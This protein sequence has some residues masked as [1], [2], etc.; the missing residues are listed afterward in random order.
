MGRIVNLDLRK[1]GASAQ[2]ILFGEVEVQPTMLRHDGA[3]T[4]LPAPTQAGLSAGL[5]SLDL[6]VSPDGPEP[7]WAYKVV[8]RDFQ[9][10]RAW[11]ELVGVP[12]GATPLPYPDLPRF[13]TAIP[14]EVTATMMQNWADTA[15]G[16]AEEAVAAADRAEAPTDQMAQNLINDAA[17]LTGTALRDTIGTMAVQRGE[18]VINVRDYGAAG[19][20]ATDDTDAIQAAMDAAWGSFGQ[21]GKLIFPAGDYWPRLPIK[22]RSGVAIE[23]EGWPI[24][25]RKLGDPYYAIFA[26]TSDG[27]RGYGSGPS[28]WTCTGIEFRGTFTEGAERS[29]CPFALHHVQ[30]ALIHGNRFIECQITGHIVDMNGCD[31]ITIRDNVFMGMK[32]SDGNGTAEACQIDQSKNGSLSYADTAGSYDG[33]MSRNITIQGNRFLPLSIGDTWYPASNI[34][35]NH[36]TRQGVYYENIKI[37]DNYVED[38]IQG[39]TATIRGNI[40][41]QGTKGVQIL[42]NKFVSTKG[43]NTKLISILTVTTGNDAN[44]DPE[45]VTP[46]GTIPAQGCLDVRVEGN[47]FE[48]FNGTSTTEYLVHVW[49]DASGP[50]ATD[51]VQVVGNTFRNNFSTTGGSDP[52][53]VQDCAGVEV[54]G[55]RYRGK[56]TRA[57]SCMSIDG[58]NVSGND[59]DSSETQVIWVDASTDVTVSLNSWRNTKSLPRVRNSTGV[60]IYGNRASKPVAAGSAFALEGCTTFSVTGNNFRTSIASAAAITLVGTNTNGQIANNTCFGYTAATTGTGANVSVGTNPV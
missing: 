20:G 49:G 33:L 21:G 19:D 27:Q 50:S 34:A 3:V 55:N 31:G 25:R 11:S 60:T 36:T 8:I 7:E 16:G 58:L 37:L 29:A 14:A 51:N 5:A 32:R 54:Q 13:T 18:L 44:S 1:G 59:I 40:H 24:I 28:N 30:N 57:A 47:T 15:K 53:K 46:V 39:L 41:L 43:G 2:D 38:P 10:G 26:A 48:G 6:A 56:H 23:G 35:G 4:V 22:L 17:S 9:T 42:R 12:A 45:V 52:I